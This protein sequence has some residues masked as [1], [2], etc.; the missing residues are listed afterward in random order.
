VVL[1]LVTSLVGNVLLFRLAIA[2]YREVSQVRLDP[3]GLKLPA[4]Q[5][6]PAPRP[7]DRPLVVLFGDSRAEQW[8]PP[9]SSRFRFLNRGIGGQTTEQVRGRVEAQVVPLKPQVMILQAGI[10]DLKAIALFPNRREQ[11]VADCKANLR[12]VVRRATDGGAVVIVATIFPTG[13]VSA[14]RQLQWSPE[15][16]KAV[17]E[18]NAD[19]RSL[20]STRVFVLDAF[21]ILQRDGRMPAEYSVDTLHLNEKAYAKLNVELSRLLDTVPVPTQ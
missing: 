16:E 4:F 21:A 8:Q 18:V 13:P 9:D 14:V 6:S 20:Q 2:N 15:I 7:S 3:Y 17:E 11:I 12:D 10:N 1:V 5:D 19:L